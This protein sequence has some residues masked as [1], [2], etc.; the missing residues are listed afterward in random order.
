MADSMLPVTRWWEVPRAVSG[1]CPLDK[2]AEKQVLQPESG[3]L[4]S[5]LV[6]LRLLSQEQPCAYALLSSIS[7]TI[8]LQASL[9]EV[10]N[11]F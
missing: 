1:L 4:P 6:L 5:T 8:R 2:A 9:G 7:E 11:G 10:T 3:A